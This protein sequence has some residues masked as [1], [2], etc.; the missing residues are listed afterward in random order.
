MKIQFSNNAKK[1]IAT[2]GV[3]L[4]LGVGQSYANVPVIDVSAIAQAVAQVENQVRQIE[5]LRQ[6]VKAATDNGNYGDLLNNSAVRQQL[7]KYL[8]AGYTDIFQ[9]AQRGDLGALAKVVEQASKAEQQAQTAQ[10]GAVRQAAVQVQSEAMVIARYNRLN[11]Y[12]QS[13]QDLSNRINSTANIAQKQDLTNTLL[14]QSALIQN[15]L[16]MIQLDMQRAEQ[17]RQRAAEQR[18]KEIQKRRRGGR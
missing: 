6:Q 10:S 5:Q 7:N 8:P 11:Q 12:A 14:A 18:V 13:V 3:I 16:G 17:Q 4:A 9:A 15:E 1:A 2:F